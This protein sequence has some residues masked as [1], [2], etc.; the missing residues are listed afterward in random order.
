MIGEELIRSTNSIHVVR[1]GIGLTEYLERF[2]SSPSAVDDFALGDSPVG[3]GTANACMFLV[4]E[5]GERLGIRI[6]QAEV[7]QRFHILGYWTASSD[8]PPNP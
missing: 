7:S 5:R 3:D 6:K 8:A 4:N 1:L 2:L